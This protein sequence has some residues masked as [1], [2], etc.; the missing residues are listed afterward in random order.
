MAPRRVYHHRSSLLYAI[1]SLIENNQG[2]KP[3]KPAGIRD[4]GRGIA[5]MLIFAALAL[6]TIW[7]IRTF[8]LGPTLLGV[9]LL[10]VLVSVLRSIHRARRVRPTPNAETNQDSRPADPR[11]GDATR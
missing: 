10:A 8:G 3:E 9:I 6:M 2:P 1:D 11:S 4:L 5:G 7:V